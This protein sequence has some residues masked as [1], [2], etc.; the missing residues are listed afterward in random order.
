[1][2]KDG[3]AHLS[4]LW[5]WIDKRHLPFSLQINLHDYLGPSINL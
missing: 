5:I 3:D 2:K 4:Q 1:M